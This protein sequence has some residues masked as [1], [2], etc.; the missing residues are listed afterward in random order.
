MPKIRNDTALQA[1]WE[2]Q[3]EIRNHLLGILESLLN[4][5]PDHNCN[6]KRVLQTLKNN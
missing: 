4:D 2:R 3:E 1:D 5:F 6:I